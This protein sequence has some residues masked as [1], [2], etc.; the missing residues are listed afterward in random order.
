MTK[1]LTFLSV[2]LQADQSSEWFP[3]WKCPVNCTLTSP[4]HPGP[5]LAVAAA[6]CIAQPPNSCCLL[7]TALKKRKT[8]AHTPLRSLPIF[9]GRTYICINEAFTKVV[10]AQLRVVLKKRCYGLVCLCVCLSD[11]LH[12]FVIIWIYRHMQKWLTKLDASVRTAERLKFEGNA[13]PY[14]E[15]SSLILIICS[16]GW[17]LKEVSF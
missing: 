9:C 11:V 8:S 1:A 14:H 3:F 5:I 15:N 7:Q 16:W 4:C 13:R 6:V 10:R 17:P 12:P 2:K